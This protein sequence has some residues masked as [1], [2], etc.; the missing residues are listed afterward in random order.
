[1]GF[2]EIA[3]EIEGRPALSS[4]YVQSVL[5]NIVEVLPLLLKLGQ[6]VKLEGVGTF[7]IS[8]TSEWPAV[9][10]ELSA[11][12]ISGVK[13]VFLPGAELKRS[14]GNITFELV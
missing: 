4:G 10:N 5:S 2:R 6:P 8:V 14:A 12:H 13:I 11:H 3:K 1:V 9:D 7:R